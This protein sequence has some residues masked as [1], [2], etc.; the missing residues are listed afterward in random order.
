M[1]VDMMNEDYGTD[2]DASE[3]EEEALK[4]LEQQSW[5]VGEA[6][7]RLMVYMRGWGY[8]VDW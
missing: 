2:L 5:L 3:H 4:A 1:A 8:M 6:F 7:V